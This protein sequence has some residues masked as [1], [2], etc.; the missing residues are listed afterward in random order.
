VQRAAIAA[1]GDLG[2]GGL[3]AGACVVGQHPDKAVQLPVEFFDALEPAFGQLDRR[4]LLLF[5][6]TG[7]LGDGEVFGDHRYFSGKAGVWAG[8]APTGRGFFTS[9]AIS[10]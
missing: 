5:D 9:R 8:S 2:L 10:A 3:G 1:G 4:Q 6:E 7:G